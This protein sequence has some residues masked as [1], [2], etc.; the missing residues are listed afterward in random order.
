MA[1]NMKYFSIIN[2]TTNDRV[3]VPTSNI[4]IAPQ[5]DGGIAWDIIYQGTKPGKKSRWRFLFLPN[6]GFTPATDAINIIRQTIIESLSSD[7]TVIETNLNCL[8]SVS[9]NV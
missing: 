4:L 2:H 5:W 1:N 3:L 8:Y 9:W 6:P 7:K